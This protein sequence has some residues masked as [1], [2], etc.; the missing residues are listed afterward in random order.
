[1]NV[2][3]SSS[4]ICVFNVHTMTQHYANLW[5]S[6]VDVATQELPFRLVNLKEL[7]WGK[8]TQLDWDKISAVEFE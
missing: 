7:L 3:A 5:D 2:L 8:S 4:L 6:K 1:M